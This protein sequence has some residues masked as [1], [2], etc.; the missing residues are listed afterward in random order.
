MENVTDDVLDDMHK[1]IENLEKIKFEL[2]IT[3]TTW[4]VCLQGATMLSNSEWSKQKCLE[5]LK[6]LVF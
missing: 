2:A 4:K 6:Y 3:C 5:L 1:F